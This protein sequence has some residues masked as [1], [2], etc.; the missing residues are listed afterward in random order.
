MHLLLNIHRVTH[1][2]LHGAVEHKR[3][4]VLT[5]SV[6]YAVKASFLNQHKDV[7]KKKEKRRKVY[8]G[9][10]LDYLSNSL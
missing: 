6:P 4:M 5:C 7:Q 10:L 1:V 2:S 8:T 9:V 3:V